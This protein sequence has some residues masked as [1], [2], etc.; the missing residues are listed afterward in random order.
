MN[1]KANARGFTLIEV[2]I[3]AM[4]LFTVV[5]TVS[6]VYQAAA[7]SSIKA[8][9][10][11][12]LSGLVPLLAD[13]IQFNLQQADTAQ[14]VTQQGI[15]NDYQFSWTATVTNKAPP[16]PRY[17]FESERFVTQDDKFYLWQVQLELLKGDYQQQY[18]FTALSW[19]GL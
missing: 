8:S 1:I 2:L 3:A 10:S 19:Q 13:T 11:V 17:E 12:E 7:T 14:T 4:I 9:R 6:Q 15:I 5:A 18:E 16:P